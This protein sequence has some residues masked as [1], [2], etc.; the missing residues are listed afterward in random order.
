MVPAQF[1]PVAVGMLVH[2]QCQLTGRG[3]LVDMGATFSLIPH[4]STLPLARQPRI[5]GPSGKPIRCWGEEWLQLRICGRLFAWT[6]LKAEVTFPILGVDFL[7]ANRLSVSVATNQLVDNSTGN[8]FHLIE[9]PSGHTASVMLPANVMKEKAEPA[10]PTVT[11]PM[12][13]LGVTYAAVAACGTPHLETAR[14]AA[15]VAIRSE[16]FTFTRKTPPSPD[17]STAAGGLQTPPPHRFTFTHRRR[18]RWGG[19]HE[20][21][22]QPPSRRFLRSSRTS[23]TQRAACS[24]RQLRWH[25]TSRPGGCPSPRNFG[26]WMPKN[27]RWQRRSS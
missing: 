25:T 3:F 23:L 9:Q 27:L 14:G 19:R 11:P 13:G 6:F 17:G 10:R 21:Q 4:S 16:D 22:C 5:I 1:N 12:G 20:W 2:V 24:A 7:R 18:P 15:L 8:T 26:G